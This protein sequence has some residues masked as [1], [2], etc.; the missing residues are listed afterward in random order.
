MKSRLFPACVVWIFLGAVVEA[1][2]PKD[3]TISLENRRVGAVTMLTT[4][5]ELKAI[6]GAE[7][8]KD[9]PIH[10]GEGTQLPGA[11]V[12]EGTDDFFEVIWEHDPKSGRFKASH[13]EFAPIPGIVKIHGRNWKIEEG[14]SLGMSLEALEKINGKPFD[15]LGFETDGAGQVASWRGGRLGGRAGVGA[16]STT[17]RSRR[18]T[19]TRFS[20]ERMTTSI[21]PAIPSFER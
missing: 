19:T 6:Y 2:D 21:S 15:F 8:V 20:P 1:G 7:H 5:K 17:P 18:R 3:R 13:G 14:V 10:H 4:P 16:G 9:A 12:F 11:K